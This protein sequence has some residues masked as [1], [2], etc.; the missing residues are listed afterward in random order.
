[1]IDYKN[2]PFCGRKV[3]AVC[4]RTMG[5]PSG[6]DGWTARI[7]CFGCN[8]AMEIWALKKSWAEKKLME[9]WNS[10]TERKEID[11]GN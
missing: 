2:C 1:M 3:G 11:D 6:D 10:R 8:A 7:H 5:V 9:R 4:T